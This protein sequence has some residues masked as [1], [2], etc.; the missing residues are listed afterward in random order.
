MNY[1]V[2]P[3]TIFLENSIKLSKKY[4]SFKDELEGLRNYIVE[5]LYFGRHISDN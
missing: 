2:I 1:R 4:P 3:S 5:N